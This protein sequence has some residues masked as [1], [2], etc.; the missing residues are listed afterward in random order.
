MRAEPNAPRTL[1]DPPIMASRLAA[2]AFALVPGA[3]II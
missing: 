1:Y 3:L 2:S